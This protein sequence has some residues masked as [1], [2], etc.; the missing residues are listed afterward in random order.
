MEATVLQLF[1]P[2]PVKSIEK[3][4]KI[5]CNHEG[6]FYNKENVINIFDNCSATESSASWSFSKLSRLDF[7]K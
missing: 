4:M 3:C 5:R 6:R 2:G 1:R 7:V